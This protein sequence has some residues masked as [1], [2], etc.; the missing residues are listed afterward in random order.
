MKPLGILKNGLFTQNPVLVRLLGLCPALAVST[1]LKNAAG[2][3]VAVTAVL[4]LS[5][6]LMSLLGKHIPDKI[7]PV[8]HLTVT[9]GLVTAAD[10]L[11]QA[12]FPALSDSLGIYVPLI[13]LSCALFAPTGASAAGNSPLVSALDGFSM[14]LGFTWVLCAVSAIREILGNGTI[15]GVSL[16]GGGYPPALIMVMPAGGFLTLGFL[17][18]AAQHAGRR[19]QP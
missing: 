18:A 13:A 15:W 7:R 3:G 4:V 9:A 17:M 19:K 16:F 11:M 8:A 10:L 1:S 14:G 12:Y 6:L 2:M 5:N